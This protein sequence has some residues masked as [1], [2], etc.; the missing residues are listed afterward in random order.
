MVFTTNKVPRRWGK[1]LHDEDLA[2]AIVDRSLERGRVVVLDGPSVRT[3][4]LPLDEGA[5]EPQDDMDRFSGKQAPDFPEP[6]PAP[7][8][9]ASM[10]CSRSRWIAWVARLRGFSAPGSTTSQTCSKR[11]MS[12]SSSNEASAAL[13]ARR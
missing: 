1:V 2:E 13:S 5:S 8:T 6:T 4:H 11:S 12:T 10:R 9:R 7:S 3:K